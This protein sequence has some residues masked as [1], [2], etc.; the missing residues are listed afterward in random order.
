MCVYLLAL[1]KLLKTKNN[2]KTGNAIRALGRMA[3]LSANS[4]RN[5]SSSMTLNS[6]RPSINAGYTIIDPARPIMQV[7]NEEHTPDIPEENQI[8]VIDS[9]ELES[10]VSPVTLPKKSTKE[11]SSAERNDSGFSDCSISSMVTAINNIQP[12]S[13]VVTVHPLFSVVNSITEEKSMEKDPGKIANN[14]KIIDMGANVSVNKLK[15]KFVEKDNKKQISNKNIPKKV[16]R[17]ASA[18]PILTTSKIE[19]VS[20]IDLKRSQ[21]IPPLQL[22][23][24]INSNISKLNN[25]VNESIQRPVL[26]SASLND[27]I[28]ENGQIMRSDFT[29]TVKM[30]KKSLEHSVQREKHLTSPRILLEPLGK[31]TKLLQRFD[32]QNHHITTSSPST[33]V[34]INEVHD[35][36]EMPDDERTIHEMPNIV[37]EPD[38]IET[39]DLN[40]INNCLEL[41]LKPKSTTL[42]KS[43]RTASDLKTKQIPK[44]KTNIKPSVFDTKINLHRS[45]SPTRHNTN[46]LEINRFATKSMAIVQ[47]KKSIKNSQKSTSADTTTATTI[48]T[49]QHKT[50]AHGSIKSSVYASFNRTSPVRLSGRVKEVTDRLSAPKGIMKRSTSSGSKK[51]IIAG[52]QH[53]QHEFIV[54]ETTIEQKANCEFTLRSKMNES[55]RKANAFW[56]AT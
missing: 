40:P 32:A 45:R 33:T 22:N 48:T 47:T 14:E 25:T 39:H 43:M 5:S 50:V 55:F 17:P 42:I 4:R 21:S 10:I 56:K 51:T 35:H 24:P 11:K 41:T 28:M 29:N 52:E 19:I 16:Q 37:T 8:D 13:N 12:I 2:Q 15:L 49:K 3:I 53:Q 27:R 1:I 20:K 34:A 9:K 7:L 46:T 38:E 44:P 23:K 36:D 31:V 30:R 54:T 6:P 18:N 26:R